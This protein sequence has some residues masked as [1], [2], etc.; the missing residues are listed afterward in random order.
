MIEV[1]D[2]LITENIPAYPNVM[3]MTF[4]FPAAAEAVTPG[5]FVNARVSENLDPPLR[6]PFSVHDADPEKGTISILYMLVGRGTE[7]MR[8]ME[9]S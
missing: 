8:R 4:E 3:R 9:A 7:L 2:C 1:R 6:R 5:Q